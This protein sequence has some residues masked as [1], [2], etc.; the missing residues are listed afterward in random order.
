MFDFT[1]SA[2]F[3]V[4]HNLQVD[5]TSSLLCSFL[6]RFLVAA[7][8][9]LHTPRSALM[10]TFDLKESLVFPPQAPPHSI[11]FSLSVRTGWPLVQNRVTV[12]PDS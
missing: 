10:H 6:A 2:H 12:V 9:R 7:A 5:S 1:Q 4:V 8:H 11:L 3:T